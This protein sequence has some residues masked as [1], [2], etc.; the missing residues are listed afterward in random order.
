MLISTINL[1]S[2]MFSIIC[3]FASLELFSVINVSLLISNA[4]SL[5]LV[6]I[7]LK[8]KIIRLPTLLMSF[9]V[10]VA[11]SPTALSSHDDLMMMFMN[12]SN[13]RK[14]LLLY[15]SLVGRLFIGHRQI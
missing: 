8:W 6:T 11:W 13:C 14:V 2:L 3:Y 15:R 1:A 10:H 5:C 9:F 4:C 12:F 7:E